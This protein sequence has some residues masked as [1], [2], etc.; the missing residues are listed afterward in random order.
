VNK[1][2]IQDESK[3]ECLNIYSKWELEKL[4]QDEFE[5]LN[6]EI[7]VCV[8]VFRIGRDEQ[9][10]SLIWGKHNSPCMEWERVGKAFLSSLFV[11]NKTMGITLS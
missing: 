3:H 11:N 10:L 5:V 7:Y 1:D 9:N 6:K 8:C 4:G 2:H